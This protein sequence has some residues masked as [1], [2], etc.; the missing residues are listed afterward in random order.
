MCPKSLDQDV[1]DQNLF[2]K[3]LF[4]TIEKYY[5]M[6]GLHCQNRH[7]IKNYVKTMVI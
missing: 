3:K 5:T 1:M 4:K 2:I 7:K 6:V